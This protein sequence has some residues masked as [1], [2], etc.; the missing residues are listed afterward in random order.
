[1]DHV[2]LS[3]NGQQLDWTLGNIQGTGVYASDHS[4][5]AK[6]A[7]FDFIVDHNLLMMVVL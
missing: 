3:N 4:V 1:M 7:D 6:Q 2:L 5:H